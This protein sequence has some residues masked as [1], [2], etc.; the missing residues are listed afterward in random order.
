MKF[1]LVTDLDN[2]LTGDNE[3][4]LILNQRLANL[5]GGF[6]LVYATGRSLASF[7]QLQQEFAAA[8][9][10]QLLEPDYLVTGVGSEIYHQGKKDQDWATRVSEDWDRGAIAHLLK[11]FPTLIP[12]S[13]AEQN[14]WKISYCFSSFNNLLENSLDN[15]QIINNL[16][17][18]LATANLTAQVIFSS[19]RDVDILPQNS[20]KGLAVTYLMQKLQINP[21]NTLICGDSGNDITMFEQQTLGVVVGNSQP[22]L[23]EWYRTNS[24]PNHYLARS[25][26]AHAIWEAMNHFQLGE[27]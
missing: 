12:Q 19:D 14:P 20:G 22:E 1:L 16:R 4:T 8:T 23:L 6:Y 11:S 15:S 13:Q 18:Q 10:E 25:P 21:Q 7:G 2:T 27:L 24:S 9:G 5:R 26:Y 3:A 17:S